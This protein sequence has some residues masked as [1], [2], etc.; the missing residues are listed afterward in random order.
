M[1]ISLPGGC[2]PAGRTATHSPPTAGSQTAHCGCSCSRTAASATTRRLRAPNRSSMPPT[3]MTTFAP[4]P[5]P[6]GGTEPLTWYPWPSRTQSRTSSC[7]TARQSSHRRHRG[8]LRIGPRPAGPLQMDVPLQQQDG[9]PGQARE[10]AGLRARQDRPPLEEPVGRNA[11]CAAAN[12]PRAGNFLAC[13]AAICGRTASQLRSS[14]H[15]GERR[16]GVLGPVQP[17]RSAT[18]QGQLSSHPSRR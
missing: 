6:I 1:D 12:Q 14:R 2:E 3:E 7:C 18:P 4:T 8:R 13:H 9:R 11:G 5:A 17:F 10:S 16:K 15:R